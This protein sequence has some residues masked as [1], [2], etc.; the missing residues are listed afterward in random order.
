[1]CKKCKKE[2]LND[3]HHEAMGV[4]IFSQ[5]KTGILHHWVLY[6]CAAVGMCVV[7]LQFCSSDSQI[8][9]PME[10]FYYSTQVYHSQLQWYLT[11]SSCFMVLLKQCLWGPDSTSSITRVQKGYSPESSLMDFMHSPV[12][13]I[14]HGITI[15]VLFTSFAECN[16]SEEDPTTR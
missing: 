2:E 4:L 16:H 6:G 5:W 15:K 14:Q 12:S 11:H 3:I 8:S 9:I 10:I 7:V 13:I 1:M